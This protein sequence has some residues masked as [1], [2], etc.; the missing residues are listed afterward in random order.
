MSFSLS[1]NVIVSHIMV[2]VEAFWYVRVITLCIVSG[3]LSNIFFVGFPGIECPRGARPLPGGGTAPSDPYGE[4]ALAFTK[5]LAL[6]HEVIIALILTF[7][8]Y[9]YS[10][11]TYFGII[12]LDNKR[13][14]SD[15]HLLVHSFN[16]TMFFVMQVEVEVES[17]DKG[18]NF[19]GWMYID[20]VN[21]SVALVQ[22][23]LSKIHFTAERSN[24]YKSLLEAEE[25]AK[26]KKLNVSST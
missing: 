9:S 21:L 15:W 6:Q 5:D 24:Y 14:V 17:M 26:S 7:C 13:S 16:L 8:S 12:L 18:G 22:E 11:L 10:I 23:G 25:P 19:I 20:G 3:G 2:T 1:C 4:E